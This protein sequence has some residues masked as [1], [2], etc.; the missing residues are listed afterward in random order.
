MN[1]NSIRFDNFKSFN[2]PHQFDFFGGKPGLY[3]I[4]GENTANPELGANGCGKTS[5]ID[6]IYWVFYGKTIQRLKAGD[7]RTWGKGGTTT[8]Q[9]TFDI[10]G[11]TYTLV[12]A[13]S[14]NRL[15]LKKG[16]SEFINVS[17][18]EVE[19]L[20][21]L[22]EEEFQNTVVFGQ[23]RQWFLDL[24]PS[25]MLSAFTDILN[26]D[27][28]TDK[29]DAASSKAIEAR[30]I[31]EAT[32]RLIAH[33]EGRV[34][35]MRDALAT[36]KAAAKIFDQEVVKSR[37]DILKKLSET[38]KL[39]AEVPPNLCAKESQDLAKVKNEILIIQTNIE[40]LRAEA[41]RLSGLI[42]LDRIAINQNEKMILQLATTHGKCSSCGQPISRAHVKAEQT[43]FAKDTE[44][45]KVG[46]KKT[47]DVVDGL[48]QNKGELSKKLADLLPQ[49]DALL[50]ASYRQ[51]AAN[52]LWVAKMTSLRADVKYLKSELIRLDQKENW[53]AE[54]AKELQSQLD[55]L[56]EHLKKLTKERDEAVAS[57]ASY[58]YWVKGFKD[59]RLLVIEQA[60]SSLEVKINNSLVELGLSSWT[61]GLDIERE[62]KSGGVT[63]GFNVLVQS[64][65][66]KAQV[67]WGA[68][69]GGEGQRLRLAGN[70]GLADLILARRGLQPNIEIYDEPSKHLSDE[71]LKSLVLFL[72]NRARQLK[73]QIWLVDHQTINSGL[74]AGTLSIKKDGLGS[75]LDIA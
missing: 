12:R 19:D 58:E 17:Q 61:I 29:S 45:L 8:V 14:P 46:I 5:L 24:Q 71:G 53:S 67:P 66:N 10:S 73:K 50:T 42:H 63:K 41:T 69:S 15:E 59:I 31:A 1:L 4:T 48:N 16:S 60:L 38:N 40:G 30:R 37:S 70:T 35:S 2:G 39:L 57:A 3:F 75:R 18:E 62:N 49:R 34:V 6:A 13:W 51:E 9:I 47:Q 26:L 23:F 72:H 32:E 27:Y 7:V 54:K 74:F 28:W 52:N 68:W 25:Q 44:R 20:I 21:G 36:S 33:N 64:P 65:Y 22:S 11:K 56:A 43:R 55:S